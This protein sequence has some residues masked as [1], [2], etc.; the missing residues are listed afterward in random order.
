M[1]RRKR[2]G[3]SIY[4]CVTDLINEKWKQLVPFKERRFNKKMLWCPYSEQKFETILHISV[5]AQT[6]E[7]SNV[8]I[9]ILVTCM[10][11]P[12]QC[13]VHVSGLSS[14]NLFWHGLCHRKSRPSGWFD[15]RRLIWCLLCTEFQ[16][17]AVVCQSSSGSWRGWKTKKIFDPPKPSNVCVFQ[18]FMKPAPA[19]WYGR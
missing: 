10:C 13:A 14:V 6:V 9:T 17:H 4:R 5:K 8:V 18:L 3:A 11:A 15:V 16:L 1:V 12:Q 7:V 19:N 2:I